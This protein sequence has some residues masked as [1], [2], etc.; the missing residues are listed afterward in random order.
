MTAKHTCPFSSKSGK[1][2]NLAGLSSLQINENTGD[3]NSQYPTISITNT[4]PGCLAVLGFRD[5]F[6]FFDVNFWIFRY[7]SRYLQTRSSCKSQALFC[8]SEGKIFHSSEGSFFSPILLKLCYPSILDDIRVTENHQSSY[9]L[10][11]PKHS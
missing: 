11:R 3:T 4:N 9:L 7:A 6:L 10:S 8:S 2:L 5:F 1:I